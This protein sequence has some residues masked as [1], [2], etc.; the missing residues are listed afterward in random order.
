MCNVFRGAVAYHLCVRGD[1]LLHST[2]SWPRYTL[3]HEARKEAHARW[4]TLEWVSNS[5]RTCRSSSLWLDA[6]VFH[7]CV[8]RL[9]YPSLARPLI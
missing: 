9:R 1:D 5:T 7:V 3:V 6:T 8:I 4:L 2:Q